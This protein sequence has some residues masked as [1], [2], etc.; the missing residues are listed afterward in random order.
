MRVLLPLAVLGAATAAQAEQLGFDCDFTNRC[1]ESGCTPDGAN[2]Q[3][4]FDTIAGTGEMLAGGQS[5]PGIYFT[6]DEMHHFVFVNAAGSELTSITLEGQVYY[7]GQ[8][9]IGGIS[10]WYHR[11]GQCTGRTK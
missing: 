9:S 2:Y 6:S 7:T 1:D 10:S 8:M 11:E 5:F 4:R 3:F